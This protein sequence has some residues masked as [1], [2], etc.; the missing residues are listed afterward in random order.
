LG[1]V[2]LLPRSVPKTAVVRVQTPQYAAPAGTE[3]VPAT[4]AH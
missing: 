1:L 2:L 4:S 3:R